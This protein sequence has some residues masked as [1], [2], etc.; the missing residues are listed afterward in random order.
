MSAAGFLGMLAATLSS[1]VESIGDYY[2]AARICHAPIPPPSAMNR[3]IA[4]EGVASLFSGMM[5]AGHATTSYTHNTGAIGITKVSG[6][7]TSRYHKAPNIT[8]TALQH[9]RMCGSS[10]LFS[11]S[12][13]KLTKDAFNEI[14]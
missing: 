10:E 9:L 13:P 3:A 14:V 6:C 7:C 4:I 1:V 12:M 5:G 2:A 11:H 8:R